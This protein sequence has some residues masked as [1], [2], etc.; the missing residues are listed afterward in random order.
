MS[1]TAFMFPGQGTQKAGMGKDF[2]EN[3]QTAAGIFDSASKLLDIDMK[4]LCFE[5]NDLL[6]QTEYTQAALVTTCLAITAVLKEK[7][8]KPDVT[9]GLS[10]GEYCAVAV[11]KGMS[12]DDAVRAVRQRGILMQ[13]A[14][15]GGQGSMAAVLGMDAQRI[16]SVLAGI[17][18]VSIANYNCP[19]QIV[20]TGWKESVEHASEALMEAGAKRV[21]PLNVSGPFHSPLLKEAGRKLGAVLESIELHSLQIPYV[22]NVTAGYVDDVREIKP[23]L[24]KQVTSSVLWQQSMENMI[25]DGVEVFVEV[26]PGKTLAGFMRKINRDVKVYNVETWRDVDKVVGELC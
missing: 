1:K 3:S 21:L 22:T 15:P 18:G 16:E 12:T 5:K 24:E 19:G 20:I 6:D 14:V 9:A 10:L 4:A 8:L 13:T 17:G 23:L 26:G 7:G 25:K 11:S 2:Y